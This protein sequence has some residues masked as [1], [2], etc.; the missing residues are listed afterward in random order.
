[1]ALDLAE[2]IRRADGTDPAAADGLFALRYGELHRL[3][4]RPLS[5]LSAGL[6]LSQW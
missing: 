5:A 2:L 1:V 3:A 6:R 4:E